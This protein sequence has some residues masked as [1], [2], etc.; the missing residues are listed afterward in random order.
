M[1]E[2]E[3][4]LKLVISF[5]FPPFKRVGGR[6]WAKHCKYFEKENINY[7]VLAGNFTGTSPWDED[8]KLFEDRITRV[9]LTEP[10]M[11][12]FK[13]KLPSN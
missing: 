11:P 8:V 4:L 10:R 7:H 2:E 6:R 5:L 1:L 12:Y 13:K 9:D 3:E